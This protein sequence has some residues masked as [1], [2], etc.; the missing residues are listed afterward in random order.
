MDSPLGP[1]FFWFETVESG[2]Q[3]DLAV[4]GT[5][6]TI[7]GSGDVAY[8]TFRAQS[9][10]Y[11]LDFEG[12]TLRGADNQPLDAD[13]EGLEMKPGL[14]TVFRLVG[15]SP[16]PFNPVTKIAYHVPYESDVSIR[17]YDVAGREVR[18]LVDGVVEPGRHQAVWN[19]RDEA[20]EVIG[21]GVYFCVMD[22]PDYH[23]GQKMLLLK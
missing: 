6:V 5:G 16:N 7:G 4:L 22:T 12:G 17:I 21:S 1:V 13:L 15:N 19:G 8:L 20:G 14:P 2:V 9:D 11:A 23:G 10:Q 18:V 3:I